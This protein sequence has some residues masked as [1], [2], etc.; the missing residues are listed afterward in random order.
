MGL[1]KYPDFIS[2]KSTLLN[3][4]EITLAVIASMAAIAIAYIA[5]SQVNPIRKTLKMEFIRHLDEQWISPEITKVRCELWEVYWMELKKE[6]NKD[7][8]THK[9]QEYVNDLYKNSIRCLPAT[10][11]TDQDKQE[12]N[13]NLNKEEKNIEK[14]FRYLNFADVMGTIYIYKEN[15]VLKDDEIKTLYAGRLKTYL[16]FYKLY[17]DLCYKDEKVEPNAMRLLKE[18]ED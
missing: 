4:I 9:V 14:F 8:A 1:E 5:Y 7:L 12:R 6:N 10:T 13:S 18:W 2:K 16:E 3:D 15:Q 11:C 17:F